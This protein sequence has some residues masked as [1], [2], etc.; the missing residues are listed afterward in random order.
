MSS[1]S[2][3][4]IWQN[5][6]KWLTNLFIVLSSLSS[7]CA[8]PSVD[9]HKPPSLF[10]SSKQCSILYHPSLLLL[11]HP[12]IKTH[13]VNYLLFLSTHSFPQYV[14]WVLSF[15]SCL[16][17]IRCSTNF[18]CLFLFYW[19]I[20]YSF[21]S[22][23]FFFQISSLLTSFV[24]GILSISLSIYNHIS[25]ALSFFFICDEIILHSLP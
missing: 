15:P 19:L 9:S 14:L 23:S 11:C 7:I 17:L 22:S 8:L 4:N 10:C 21:L 5:W 13:E 12:L 18:N 1:A 3:W 6:T 16:F 24:H 20:K 2:S 25:F